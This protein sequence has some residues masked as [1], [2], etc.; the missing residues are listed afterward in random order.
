MNKTYRY[1][2][3]YVTASERFARVTLEAIDAI[4]AKHLAEAM[5]GE[6]IVR[7]SARRV[8]SPKEAK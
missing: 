4:D 7:A 1:I 3:E 5:E 2:V 8:R 6:V